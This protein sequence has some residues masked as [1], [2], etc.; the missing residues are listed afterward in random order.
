M[1]D[2]CGHWTFEGISKDFGFAQFPNVERARAFVGP[3]FPF[4]QVPPPAS[5]GATQTA[6]F[7]EAL[8]TGV[9]HNGR[10]VKI[11]Y[12][13]SALPDRARD[14]QHMN[15]GT[16]NIGNT[17]GPVLLFRGL[18]PL[19]GPQAVALAVMNSAGLGQS[20]ARGMKWIVLIKDH[21]G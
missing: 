14:R 13:Q 18:D 17:Q 12:S 7:Y 5:H 6:A 11:D 21:V 1:I 3:L 16:R 20:G 4:V 15:D 2:I 8:G 9:L 10:W 19:S